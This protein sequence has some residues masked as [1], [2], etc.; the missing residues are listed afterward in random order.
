MQ[1]LMHQ[2]KYRG[3]GELGFYLGQ[4]MGVRFQETAAFT[5]V[6]ALVPLPLFAA[7][8]AGAATTRRPFCATALPM[9]CK[10]RF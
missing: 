2:F 5:D 9:Y 3:Q 7:K 4:Q 1:R 6:N 8:S 10:S